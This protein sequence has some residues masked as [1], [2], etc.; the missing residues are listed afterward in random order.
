M[1]RLL[2]MESLW[3]ERRKPTPLG[4]LIVG[5]DALDEQLDGLDGH[6]RAAAVQLSRQTPPRALQI[7]VRMRVLRE[8]A[9]TEYRG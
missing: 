9:C 7:Q 5:I 4:V 1:E 6:G 3:K 2:N 8:R